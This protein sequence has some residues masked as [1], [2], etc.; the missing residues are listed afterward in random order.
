[1]AHCV[2]LKRIRAC[3]FSYGKLK[4]SG[5]W[6]DTGGVAIKLSEMVYYDRRRE[7][8]KAASSVFQGHFVALSSPPPMLAND[9]NYGRKAEQSCLKATAS[10]P[11]H[12]AQALIHRPAAERP[13]LHHLQELHHPGATG[14]PFGQGQH[15]P[16]GEWAFDFI[17]ESILFIDYVGEVLNYKAVFPKNV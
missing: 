5:N 8:L 1:M 9:M 7:L 17:I 14:P 3:Q 15:G 13:H 10:V 4:H 11:H 6:H 2:H 12:D 16:R